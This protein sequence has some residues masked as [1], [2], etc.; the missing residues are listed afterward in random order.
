MDLQAAWHDDDDDNVLFE[1]FIFS[2]TFC[3]HF[4]SF[5]IW[6]PVPSLSK[7]EKKAFTKNK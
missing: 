6:K 7:S 4:I 1:L 2:E 3:H 5:C